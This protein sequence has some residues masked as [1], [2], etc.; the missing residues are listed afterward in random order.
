MKRTIFYSWQSDTKSFVSRNLIETAIERAIKAL[1]KDESIIVDAVLDRDTAGL[2]GSPDISDAIFEKIAFA[3]VFVADVSIINAR[4]KVRRT[5][6]P[7]V[8]I[9]L[10]YAISILGWDRIILVVNSYFGLPEE[11][12]FDL[13][14]RR[15]ISYKASPDASKPSKVRDQLQ[16]RLEAALRMALEDS[17]RIGMK[18]AS[19]TPLWWGK[20][21]IPS[22][23]K[24]HFGTL[25]IYEVG[26]AGFMFH[27]SV[28]NGSHTGQMSEYA[29]LVSKDKAYIRMPGGP[30]SKVCELS[31]HRKIAHG[32]REIEIKETSSCLHFHGM[33]V[34]FDGLFLRTT[35]NLFELGILDE[36]DIQRLYSITGE[37]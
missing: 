11:L 26:P 4:S 6:N 16:G 23:G 21:Q 5:P 20:W 3:D 37:Y 7:N 34:T 1:S 18:D 9:E 25:F 10:G 22:A 28:T 19:R 29:P 8:L 32:R 15:I 12:P 14:G 33:A 36:L 17:T 35:D 13:R 31:F 27:L 2:P 24:A 30:L